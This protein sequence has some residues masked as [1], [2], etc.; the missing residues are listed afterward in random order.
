MKETSI[1]KAVEQV[2][3]LTPHSVSIRARCDE[4]PICC[5]AVQYSY[6][7]LC[8]TRNRYRLQDRN[9]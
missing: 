4:L 9:I 1:L 3:I 8:A 6:P 7:N 2:D 5:L